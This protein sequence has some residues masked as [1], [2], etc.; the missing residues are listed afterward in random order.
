M[1]ITCSVS[2]NTCFLTYSSTSRVLIVFL[3]EPLYA[4]VSI[5]LGFM[6]DLSMSISPIIYLGR[7][8]NVEPLST[9]TFPIRTSLHRTVMYNGLSSPIPIGSY[10][11]FMK[12]T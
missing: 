7:R 8:F 10:S 6:C 5:I 11:S 2:K 3:G 1:S 9:S 4:L 12:Y